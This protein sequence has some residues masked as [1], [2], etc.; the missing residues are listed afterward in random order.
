MRLLIAMAAAIA[1][2]ATAAAAEPVLLRPAQVFDGI[3]PH[4]HAGWQVLV[5]GD[6]IAAVGPNLTAPAGT[7]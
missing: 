7:K 1:S 6:R 3:D 4:P 2:L 5:Q